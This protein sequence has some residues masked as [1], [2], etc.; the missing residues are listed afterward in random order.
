ML[1]SA[2]VSRD[3][4]RCLT[5]AGSSSSSISASVYEGTEDLGSYFVS[6]WTVD[7]RADSAASSR[8]VWPATRCWGD[9]GCDCAIGLI[10]A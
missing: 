1:T 2:A 7:C 4:V 6:L 3:G 8:T 9:R 5:D 10:L